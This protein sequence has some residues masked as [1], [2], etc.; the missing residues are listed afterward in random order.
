MHKLCNINLDEIVFDPLPL[1][2]VPEGNQGLVH[3]NP[4]IAV[5]FSLI[6]IVLHFIFINKHVQFKYK[7]AAST[8]VTKLERFLLPKMECYAT[9]WQPWRERRNLSPPLPWVLPSL[10]LCYSLYFIAHCN[11]NSI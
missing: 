9:P 7:L 11:I 8:K 6:Y 5:A 3:V 2:R 4:Q 10:S 1:L